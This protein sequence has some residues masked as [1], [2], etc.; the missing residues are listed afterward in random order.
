MTIESNKALVRSIF[1]EGVSKGEV[2][3]IY[4][5][6]SPDFIDHDIQPRPASPAGRMTCVRPF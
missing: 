4:A 3:A 5:A 2:D 1:E 6:T